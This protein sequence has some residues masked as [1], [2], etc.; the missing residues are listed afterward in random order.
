M[1]QI[2]SPLLLEKMPPL[3][4]LPLLRMWMKGGSH[5]VAGPRPMSIAPCRKS[6]LSQVELS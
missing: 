4:L 5:S 3:Q 6:H 1:P 2:L